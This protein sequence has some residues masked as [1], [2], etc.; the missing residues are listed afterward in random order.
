[1]AVFTLG[2]HGKRAYVGRLV[3][4]APLDVTAV[5][6]RILRHLRHVMPIGVCTDDDRGLLAYG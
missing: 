5:D 2:Q 6:W 1:M 4:V 3:Y